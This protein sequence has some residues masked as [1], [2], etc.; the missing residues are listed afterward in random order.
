MCPHPKKRG[1]V[2]E[3]CAVTSMNGSRELSRDRYL[4]ACLWHLGHWGKPKPKHQ[5]ASVMAR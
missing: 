2:D 4:R 1:N 3:E 5:R